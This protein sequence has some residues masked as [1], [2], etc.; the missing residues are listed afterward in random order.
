MFSEGKVLCY[1]VLQIMLVC[2]WYLSDIGENGIRIPLLLMFALHICNY[3][4]INPA[5]S[6][7]NCIAPAYSYT[8]VHSITMHVHCLH[9][10]MLTHLLFQS[11]FS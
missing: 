5:S 9:W 1:M 4:S 2:M 7:T 11:A 10:L 3:L 8:A 6:H